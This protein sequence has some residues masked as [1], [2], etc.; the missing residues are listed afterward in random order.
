MKYTFTELETKRELKQPSH[1]TLYF[2]SR[3]CTIICVKLFIM[4]L[5]Q[6]NL[7]R[8][9]LYIYIIVGLYHLSLADSAV[10]HL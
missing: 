5:K 7:K 10:P 8:V 6:R 9:L 3:I 4:W 1:L 2:R